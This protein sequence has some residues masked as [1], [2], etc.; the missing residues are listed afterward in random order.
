MTK[1]MALAAFAGAVIVQLVIL[2]AVP[3][4]KAITRSTGRTV[5]L[6]VQPVGPYNSLSGYYV[7]LSL[8]ISRRD[9]FGSVPDFSDGEEC[10]AVIERG[11]DGIWKPVSLERARPSGLPENRAVVA[12]RVEHGQLRYG[13]E[14][15]YIPEAQRSAIAEDLRTNRDR[16]KVEAKVDSAGNAA[17]V[18]LMIEDRVYQ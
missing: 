12:G 15:F 5:V 4:R 2:T 11:E 3:A 18:K 10:F 17:L 16:A 8:E 6:K 14:N 7:M 13:I 9:A 1:R